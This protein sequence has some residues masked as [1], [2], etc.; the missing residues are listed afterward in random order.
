MTALIDPEEVDQAVL[1]CL[2]TDEEAP[3]DAAPPGAVIV[4]GIVRVF[5]FHPE[6]LAAQRAAVERWIDALPPEFHERGG[7]G[8]SFL[9]LCMDRAGVQWT[10]LHVMQEALLALAM[11]LGLASYC[12]PREYWAAMP[13]GMPYVVFKQS[14]QKAAAS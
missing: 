9:N 13:G 8:M 10:G 14:D 12:L 5:A 7:G 11:G 2:F 1:T 3:G 4:Q 6:R